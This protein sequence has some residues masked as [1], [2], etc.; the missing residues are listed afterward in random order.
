MARWGPEV[1]RQPTWNHRPE[2]GPP[3]S[4]LA[5]AVRTVLD[6]AARMFAGTVELSGLLAA[7]TQLDGPLRVAFA[8]RL[9]AGKSTLLNALVGEGLAATDATECTRVVTWYVSGPATRAWAFPRTGEAEQLRFGRSGGTT[10]IDLGHFDAADLDR[11]VVE[12]PNSR[13]RQLTLVD[14]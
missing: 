10:S 7:R 2:D 6:E 14:T 8:G 5:T 4:N 3:M 9:K 11:L 1:Y 12:T 13:L